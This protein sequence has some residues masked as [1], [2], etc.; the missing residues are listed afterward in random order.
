MPE[1]HPAPDPIPIRPR[2]RRQSPSLRELR[3]KKTRTPGVQERAAKTVDKNTRHVATGST[4]TSGRNVKGLEESMGPPESHLNR[5]S[6]EN[7]ECHTKTPGPPASQNVKN[8]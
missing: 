4:R 7:L 6:Y 2:L 3:T 8:R 1:T 5:V